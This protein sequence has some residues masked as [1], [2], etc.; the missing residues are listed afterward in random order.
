MKSASKK[1]RK[2]NFIAKLYSGASVWEIERAA[3]QGDWAVTAGAK[4]VRRWRGAKFTRDLAPG[5][6][7]E[8]MVTDALETL[9]EALDQRNGAIFRQISDFFEGER[10]AQVKPS[11]GLSWAA[12]FVGFCKGDEFNVRGLWTEQK[13]AKQSGSMTLVLAWRRPPFT[14][15]VRQIH[16]FL[17]DVMAEPPDYKSAERYARLLGI[18]AKARR[19]DNSSKG[20]V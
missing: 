16:D 6:R 1:G 2:K 18:R 5:P 8:K 9:H 3:S 4:I 12:Y 17:C 20:T 13:L 19:V 10:A 14:P 15:T 11:E 7:T